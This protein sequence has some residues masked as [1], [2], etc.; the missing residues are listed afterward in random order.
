MPPEGSQRSLTEKTSMASRPNQKLGMDTP[1]VLSTVPTLSTERCCFTAETT[2]SGMANARLAT[3]EV[4]VSCWD[5][6]INILSIFWC[7]VI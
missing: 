7:F 3:K 5:H 4:T 2:P 1:A 6:V